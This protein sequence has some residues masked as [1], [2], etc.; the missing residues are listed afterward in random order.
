[1]KFKVVLIGVVLVGVLVIS[2]CSLFEERDTKLENSLNNQAN[3]EINNVQFAN[4]PEVGKDI[5]DERGLH[6]QV[7]RDIDG[8]KY[9]NNI[10]RFSFIVPNKWG[11]VKDVVS[12]G[13]TG[14]KFVESIRIIDVNNT[15][16]FIDIYVVKTEDKN[17]ATITDAPIT[18][19]AG[20]S[21]YSF[22]W[23]GSADGAGMPGLEDQ[24]YMDILVELNKV[25]NTF[26]LW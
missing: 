6:S 22:Y 10:Y 8:I 9:S 15:E 20:D 24:K 11:N 17:H 18:Y 13:M 2:G 16:K 23:S 4:V 12:E 7:I 21:T 5:E 25:K 14:T 19:L 26:K 1:M 3:L